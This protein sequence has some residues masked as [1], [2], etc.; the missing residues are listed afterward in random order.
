VDQPLVNSRV[1]DAESVDAAVEIL[2]GAFYS[3]PLW[4]WAFPDPQ[5]RRDQHRELW[6]ACVE[7][8]I[9]Y[10]WVW[11]TEGGSATSVWIPPGGSEFSDEQEQRLEPLLVDLLGAGAARV[12]ATFELFEQAH[13]RSVPH[14]Y[15]TLLGT[16]PEQRGRGHGLAL[17][18]DNLRRIDEAKAPAYL[19][20]SNVANVTLYA[21]YGFVAMG[22]FRPPDGGPEVV[23]MWRE[24]ADEGPASA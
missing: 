14:F 9:R 13:P 16:D 17:L 10:P 5:L 1:V 11:L 3:D 15:L 22:S 20:A 7:G 23:T 18:A 4:S 2:V 19:E 6:R 12:L 24:P 21:R 8:A